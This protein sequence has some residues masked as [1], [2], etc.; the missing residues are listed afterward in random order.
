[1]AE[2][3]QSRKDQHL[4]LCIGAPVGFR[5]RSNLLEQVE[6]IHDALPEL[7]LDEV[8]CSCTLLGRRLEAPIII[9]AMTGGTERAS[10]INRDLAVVAER[11]G[12]GLAFGS[13]RRQLLRGSALGFEVRDVAPSV[14][15]LGNIGVVQAS[16]AS[17]AAL[18]SMVRQAGCDALCVH[19]NPAMELVQPEGD[20][21][22]REG[23]ATLRR[24]VEQLDTP[25]VAKETGCG[26]SRSVARRLVDAGVEV[27][28][29]SGAGGTSWVGVETLRAQGDDTARGEVFW[30]WGIP[31]AASLLQ[32]DGLALRSIATGGLRTG[33]D[34]LRALALGACA[35]GYA[36]AV[37]QAWHQGG[38][39][40]AEAYLRRV[41]A[42]LRMGMLLTG[43]RDLESLRR[44]PLLLG[45]ELARWLPAD[46][47]LRARSLG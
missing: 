3:I 7:A 20:L 30:D 27:V 10:A 38:R 6:L 17:A 32:C 14:L 24:L 11:L 1:V 36:R 34:A 9:A 23:L 44:Q 21:D 37:L 28:D 16:E 39:D 12:I 35:A 19:L 41:I 43:S 5:Q 40:G 4:D 31:T 42:E 46:A 29:V 13:Q 2:I 15:L 18:E 22:F 45:P 25:V 8:D 26:I 33:L 47:P